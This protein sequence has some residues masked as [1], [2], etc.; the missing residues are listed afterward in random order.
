MYSTL[1]NVVAAI[2]IFAYGM[3]REIHVMVNRNTDLGVRAPGVMNIP[4]V[5]GGSMGQLA[6]KPRA[7]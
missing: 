5:R 4:V 3:R 7:G 2:I 1:I 6:Q